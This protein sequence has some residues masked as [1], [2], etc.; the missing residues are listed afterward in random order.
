M[1]SKLLLGLFVL[2]IFLLV[3]TILDFSNKEEGVK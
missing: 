2:D 1:I 3:K